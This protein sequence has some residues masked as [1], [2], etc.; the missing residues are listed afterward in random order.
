[1][2]GTIDVAADGGSLLIRFPY[3]EYLVEE[4]R[5]IPGRRWDKGAKVWRVPVQHVELVVG[6][7]LRH[8]FQLAPE[9]SGLL[10][11]TVGGADAPAERGLFDHAPPVP[12]PQAALSLTILNERVRT[13]V[14]G[15]FPD[16]VWVV[17]EVIDYDKSKRRKHAFFALVEKQPG[18]DEPAARAEVALFASAAERLAA[19]LKDDGGKAWL[20]DGIE[21][22]LL[23]RI[24]LYP[25]S[26]RYQLV[27]EDVDPTFTLGQ[28]ALGR[29][30]I[31]AELRARGLERRN[32][33][34]PLPLP[35]LRV[36]VLTSPDSDAWN[37]F[38]AEISASRFA[39]AVTCYAIPVQGR[40]LRPAMLRGLR[41]FAERAADFDVLC[42]LRGGGSRTDLAWFDDRE[43]A[44]AVALHPCKIACGIGH[45]RDQSVLD[46]IAYSA[47][48]PTAVAVHLVDSVR[49]AEHAL[50]SRARRLAELTEHALRLQRRRVVDFA[51]ALLRGLEGRFGADRERFAAAGRRLQRACDA[52]LARR[53]ERLAA[54]AHG[55]RLLEPR[56]VL[57][58]GYALVRTASGALVKSAAAL[59]PGVD[60]DIA[61]RDGRVRATA[62]EIIQDMESA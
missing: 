19:K 4:V 56:A 34:L 51:Q 27:V 37:D 59:R 18:E 9:V 10:A 24:D 2:T 5:T 22:R 50:A 17:G 55:L 14:R 25:A 36:G 33:E 49:S 6:T 11:G 23:V 28:L 12:E 29:E 7:F 53:R 43:L 32:L 13:A 38:L 52:L 35:P 21:V 62:T 8:G 39:F 1:M 61:L 60:I 45:Q 31:L 30:A 26:G 57:Q 54:Q 48:T 40:E 42:V 47:K 44:F 15:A 16:P 3:S 46:A 41:W 20:R 58:R